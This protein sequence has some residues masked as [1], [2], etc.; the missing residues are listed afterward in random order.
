MASSE[1]FLKRK[2]LLWMF[3]LLS[4]FQPLLW[5]E[6][7]ILA[8]CASFGYCLSYSDFQCLHPSSSVT[9]L[10][11]VPGGDTALMCLHTRTPSFPDTCAGGAFFQSFR[12]LSPCS[13]VQFP[14][15]AGFCSTKRSSCIFSQISGMRSSK[16]LLGREPR[17]K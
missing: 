7:V 13:V 1:G 5:E 15:S 11:Q 12:H 16:K 9:S 10:A 8:S 6:P 4:L 2:L 17:K 3:R 14:A